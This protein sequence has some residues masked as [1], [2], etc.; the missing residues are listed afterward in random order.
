M[1][2]R[3]RLDSEELRKV[4]ISHAAEAPT[5][6]PLLALAPML[7]LAVAAPRWGHDSRAALRSEEQRLAGLGLSW[8]P[9]RGRA[10][11]EERA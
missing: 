1:S 3:R 4:Y 7:I 8:T 11:E 10:R 9:D 6:E 2:S 5:M